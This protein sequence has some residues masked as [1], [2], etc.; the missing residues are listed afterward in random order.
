M[1]I[2]KTSEKLIYLLKWIQTYKNLWKSYTELINIK[3]ESSTCM[4]CSTTVV[5]EVN[6]KRHNFQTWA[7]TQMWEIALSFV[8][9]WKYPGCIADAWMGINPKQPIQGIGKCILTTY[10]NASLSRNGI[11]VSNNAEI[12]QGLWPKRYHMQSIQSNRNTLSHKVSKT[13]YSILHVFWC[14]IHILAC[15]VHNILPLFQSL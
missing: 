13:I 3:K 4:C 1:H 6:W 11:F 14:L 15:H 5:H 9:I 10:L 12:K 8:F 2:Y 7:L